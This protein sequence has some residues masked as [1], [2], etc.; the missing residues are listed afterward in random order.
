MVVCLLPKQDTRVQFPSLALQIKMG[1]ATSVSR[2]KIMQNQPSNIKLDARLSSVKAMKKVIKERKGFDWII[3]VS[4]N[5]NQADFWKERLSCLTG[6]VVGENTK[7]VSQTEDWLNGAG[8]LLGTLYAFQKANR[9]NLSAGKQVNLLNEL[10]K[11]KKIAIYHTS[12]LGKRMAPLSLSEEC[13]SS[14]KL[15]RPIKIGEEKNFITLLEATIFS[16]QIFAPSREKRLVVFWGDQ[17]I[18]P[19]THPGMEEDC[20]VELFGIQ[21][22]IPQKAESWEREWR[23]YGI[24]AAN[25]KNEFLQR[26]KISWQVF[27]RLKRELELKDLQKSLGFFSVSLEFLKALL[28]EFKEDLKKKEGKLD[29]DPHLWTP[30]TSSRIEYLKMGGSLVHWQRIKKFKERF[31][32]N[33]KTQA[34]LIRVEDVGR[35][36]FWWDFGNI[37][38]YQRN[39]LKVLSQNS[40]GECLRKFFEL[41]R[42]RMSEMKKPGLE[43]ENSI[44]VN[45]R[46]KGKV[47]NS[48]ILNTNVKNLNV[49]K[50]LLY[51]VETPK[52]LGQEAIAYNLQEP[53]E[54]FLERR[55]V[56]TDIFSKVGKIRVKTKTFRNGKKDWENKILENPVS[57]QRLTELT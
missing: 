22:A 28:N 14:I 10:K 42:F 2:L 40:E 45:S 41:E 5:Q 32:K 30:L 12:G 16:T 4:P 44:L 29:T 11:G 8:Q 1:G 25:R 37:E 35:D 38:S 51:N 15:P 56:L 19:S 17:I 33:G 24:L 18:I 23:N 13:K 39:L 55:D 31:L 43:V 20:P 46:I 7:I 52:L 34:S 6:Q 50:S 21:K 53:K 26:E 27:K 3:I 54:I 48:L 9:R 57:Y 36:S 47:Q 49:S